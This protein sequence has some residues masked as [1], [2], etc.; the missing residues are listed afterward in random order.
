MKLS[1]TEAM[2]RL[3]SMHFTRTTA[4]LESGTFRA[5]GTRVD[6][7]PVSEQYMYQ[8]DFA[9]SEVG[10]IYKIDPVSS[11]II[12]E[13]QNI[14][15][16]PAKHFITNDAEKDRAIAAIKQELEQQLAHFEKEGKLLEAERIKRRTNYDLAIDR[17]SVV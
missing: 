13:E 2:E 8:I 7:M 12:S 9:G 11:R 14:F 15:L 16:F 5:L 6:V 1:R 4:D 10:R 17:K 3:I